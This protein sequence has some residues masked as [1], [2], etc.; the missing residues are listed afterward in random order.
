VSGE[1]AGTGRALRLS[2]DLNADVGEATDEEGI[3][4]ERA[5]LRSVTSVHVACGGHAGD[6]ASMEATVRAALAAGVRVGAHPSYPDR[7]GFGRRPLEIAPDELASSL[8]TQ[9]GS[10]LS[11]AHA[12][13]T[14]V[15]SVKAHG[16][17]YAEVAAGEVAYRALLGAV[18][19]VCPPGTALVVRAGSPAVALARAAGV[20]VWAEGFCDRAYGSDGELVARQVAGAV[21]DDPAPAV[22]QALTLARQGTVDLADGAPR[23]VHV[24][25]LCL[26]GD[27]PH[28]AAMAAAVRAALEADG[29]EV[30]A[31]P[32]P[33]S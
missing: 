2:V 27:S 28:A 32:L 7:D 4:V 1:R 12:C 14:T 29:I 19:E 6:A 21:Y 20:T 10:L 25:T 15:H 16:A 11:V 17:L 3:A 26:H 8:R 5:L 30:A 33:R 31:A 23:R 9:I 24:D 22:R 18:T 13:G